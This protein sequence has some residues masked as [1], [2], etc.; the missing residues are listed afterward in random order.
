MSCCRPWN[1][2]GHSVLLESPCRNPFR[3]AGNDGHKRPDDYDGGRIGPAI[4]GLAPAPATNSSPR[5]GTVDPSSGAIDVFGRH[6]HRLWQ[7][8]ALVTPSLEAGGAVVRDHFGGFGSGMRELR[9]S[10]QHYPR[11]ERD[12]LWHLK[13]RAKWNPGQRQRRYAEYGSEPIG[14]A[15]YLTSRL[16][17]PRRAWVGRTTS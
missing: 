10:Y 11:G 4:E 8:R 9:E 13:Y 15:E 3:D 17:G 5:R 2:C 16:A 14:S 12:T 6:R 1:P 7:V